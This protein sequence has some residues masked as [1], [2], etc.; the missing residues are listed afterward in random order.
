M[1]DRHLLSAGSRKTAGCI[2]YTGSATGIAHDAAGAHQFCCLAAIATGAADLFV[3]TE[4]QLLETGVTEF[5]F[6][7]V[8]GHS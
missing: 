2:G 3:V 8:N 7:F 6:I 5:T 1:A 4:D